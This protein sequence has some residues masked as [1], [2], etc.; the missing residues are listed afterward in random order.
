MAKKKKQIDP[1]AE[2]SARI[3]RTEAYAERIRLMFA[4]TVNQILAL[5]KTIPHLEPG[6]MFSFDGQSIKK[7]NEVE[8][9][10]RQLHSVAT[11]AI[12]Q[13]ITLEWGQANAAADALVRSMFGQEVLSSPEFTAWNSRNNAA[14]NAFI[15]RS[16]KGLNLSDRVWRAVRQL[17]D[18]ME[19]AITVSIGEGQS[20]QKMSQS[21]RKYLND[22]DLMFRRF[23]YKAGEEIEY[24]EEGNEIGKKI[25]WGKKWKKRIKKPDGTYG[26]IDYDKDSYR[27]GS[28]VYKSSAQNAMRVARTE[29]NIAYRRADHERWQDMDFVLGQRV[30]MSNSHPKKDICD[31]LAGDYPKDFVFDGWHPQCFCFVTP[32][33][34]PPE[35]TEHLTEMM[36]NGEDWRSELAR[37]KRG[38]EITSYPDNFKQWVSD[39]ADNIAAARERGTEPYFIRNNSRAINQILHPE[40][41]KALTPLQIAQKRHAERTPEQEDAIRQRWQERKERIEAE[42]KRDSHIS[43]VTKS[44]GNRILDIMGD[45]PGVDT[46]ALQSAIKSGNTSLIQEEAQKLRALGKQFKADAHSALGSAADY[47]EISSDAL[48][49]AIKA[50]NIKSIWQET[51]ALQKQISTTKAAEEALGDIIPDA[52]DWHKKFTLSELEATKS[53]VISRMARESFSSAEAKKRWLE[54]EIKWVEDHKK[55]DTWPVAKAAYEKELKKVE[56]EIE[57]QS[58]STSVQAAITYALTESNNTELR[59]LA[60]QV[61]TALANPSISVTTLKPLADKLN[62]KYLSEYSKVKDWLDLSAKAK[63]ALDYASRSKDNNYISLATEVNN[64]LSAKTGEISIAKSKVDKLIEEYRKQIG[65][66]TTLSD[67]KKAMG[68]SMPETL[69]NLSRKLSKPGNWTDEEVD[70]MREKMLELFEN[71]DFGMNVPRLSNSGDDVLDAIFDSYFKSQIET[72]T[73]KGAVNMDLRKRASRDLF[74]TDISTATPQDYEKYGFLMDRD[75]L[76]Q[77]KSRIAGQYWS[78]GDGIQIRFNK[79][80]VI[81]TFTMC[82]SLGLSVTPSL[83]SDPHAASFKSFRDILGSSVSTKS[84]IDCTN[85]WACGYI[86]LQYHGQLTLDCIESIF[87]PADVVPKISASAMAKMKAVGCIIYTTDSKGNLTTLH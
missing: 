57:V 13:G 10:L 54:S 27:T 83:T 70:E 36:L 26:W 2:T 37:L 51:K 28:G 22:P 5:N 44:Y 58:I 24:D 74:G 46:S 35:E 9:L 40:E 50:G 82:D 32:I 75:I 68:D 45:I 15:N 11:M 8:R 60:M 1:K 41:E 19:V 59:D 14:R 49:A 81:A 64:L 16:E 43:T 52:H 4:A 62:A 77:S 78:Y 20:A 23:R 21:I 65:N 56:R 80:K 38:R 73:G 33:T 63:T 67:L 86:E 55:Y 39:N 42:Q 53:A 48:N 18:E 17:R 72:G 31:K 61:K 79:D 76:R 71:S 84:A 3:K 85:N 6:V 12:Q 87:I 7:Q 30:Q 69:K 25:I 66:V 34:I 29:T 47:G